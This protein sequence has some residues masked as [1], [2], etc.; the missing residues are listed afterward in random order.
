MPMAMMPKVSSLP[1]RFRRKSD[2]VA[3]KTT[4]N[5]I[6]APPI[7]AICS[8]QPRSASQPLVITVSLQYGLSCGLHEF[9]LLG[10]YLSRSPR[11]H[12]SRTPLQEGDDDDEDDHLGQR[13]RGAVFDECIQRADRERRRDRSHELT[14]AAEDDDHEG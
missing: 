3:G 7:S 13:G 10:P 8:I 1:I 12:P 5:R 6:A 4:R 9:L 2:S 11:D 14:D